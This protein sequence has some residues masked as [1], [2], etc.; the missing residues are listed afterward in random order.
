MFG[1]SNELLL[2]ELLSLPWVVWRVEHSL[3]RRS[4]CVRAS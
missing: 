1:A 2:K 4:V 3:L